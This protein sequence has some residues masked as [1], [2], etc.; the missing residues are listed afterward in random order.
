MA[1]IRQDQTQGHRP[2]SVLRHVLHAAALA[3]YLPDDHLDSL[4]NQLLGNLR[5]R[6]LSADLAQTGVHTLGAIRYRCVVPR[7]A[8]RPAP[9]VHTLGAIRCC[10]P[11]PQHATRPAPSVHTL[12]AIRYRCVVPL[13]ATRPAPSLPA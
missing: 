5:S 4:I 3:L 2:G 7:H 13:H 8:T 12:G 11:L 1:G 10:C 6:K 9:S